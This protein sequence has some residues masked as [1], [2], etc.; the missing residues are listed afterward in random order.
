MAR[1][2]M[3]IDQHQLESLCR[4]N[5]TLKDCAAFFKCSEDTI[6]RRAKAWGYESF[7]DLRNQNMVHTR[8]MLIRTAVKKA[9]G[10]CKTMLIF[11]LKNL[12]GWHDNQKVDL[13]SDGSFASLVEQTKQE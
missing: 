3:K 6:E 7:A 2:K 13:S 4:L 12:C 9:E 1:P 8:L 10:G 5:P 11:C